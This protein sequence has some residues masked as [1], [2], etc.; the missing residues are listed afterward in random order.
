MS[1]RASGK[2]HLPTR[3]LKVYQAFGE[4]RGSVY[5]KRKRTVRKQQKRR[6]SVQQ[7]F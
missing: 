2:S 6:P 5:G 7:E 3:L 1:E 4:G